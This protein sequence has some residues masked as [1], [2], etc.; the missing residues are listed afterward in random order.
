MRLLCSSLILRI[1]Y[2]SPLRLASL[3]AVANPNAF[4]FR[5][6]HPNEGPPCPHVTQ[7]CSHSA[8]AA[9]RP[10]HSFDGEAERNDIQFIPSVDTDSDFV[11]SK[12]LDELDEHF[13]TGEAQTK[14][15]LIHRAAC[16]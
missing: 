15:F 6:V 2:W 1:L 4:A 13:D 9:C 16:R 14:R 12:D 3:V 8:C 11:L 5:L 7:D 10:V